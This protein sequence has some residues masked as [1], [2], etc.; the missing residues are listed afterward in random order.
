MID[1]LL[2]IGK[3]DEA[4]VSCVELVSLLESTDDQVYPTTEEFDLGIYNL[5]KKFLEFKKFKVIFQLLHCRIKLLK[6]YCHG[7]VMCVKM[8]NISF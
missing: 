6:R 8:V 4:V 5:V 1:C 3:L 7:E 2:K